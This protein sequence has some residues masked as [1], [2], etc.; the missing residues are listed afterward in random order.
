MTAL[1]IITTIIIT[2]LAEPVD[3]VDTLITGVMAFI[4]SVICMMAVYA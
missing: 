3:S 1:I 2:A 4:T